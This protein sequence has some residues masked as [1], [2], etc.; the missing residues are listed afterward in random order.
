VADRETDFKP[1]GLLISLAQPAL[2][3][4]PI[5]LSVGHESQMIKKKYV[6]VLSNDEII[7]IKPF[8]NIKNKA[9]WK[10]LAKLNRESVS[11]SK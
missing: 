8:L 1:M 3:D 9:R 10:C 7:R 5:P 4:A 2:K 11:L 6:I